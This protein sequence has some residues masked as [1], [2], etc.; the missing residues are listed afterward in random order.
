MRRGN[1]SKLRVYFTEPLAVLDD[2]R[3]KA[4]NKIKL[5]GMVAANEIYDA[6]PSG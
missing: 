4:A 1:I 6:Q 3:L 2:I 5:Y